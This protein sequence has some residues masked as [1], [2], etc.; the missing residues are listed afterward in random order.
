MTVSSPSPRCGICGLVRTGVGC[1]RRAAAILLY[2]AYVAICLFI[3]F[4]YLPSDRVVYL[5]SLGGV[6]TCPESWHRRTR[7]MKRSSYC[8]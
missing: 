5:G 8:Y 2:F 6:Q 4:A 7:K 3:S 1:I